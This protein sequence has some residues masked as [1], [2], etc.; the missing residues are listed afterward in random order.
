MNQAPGTATSRDPR[1]VPLAT[2]A[3]TAALADRIAPTLRGGDVL[4]LVGELGTGKTTLVQAMG[5]YWQVDDGQIRSPTFALVNVV[6]LDSFD[7]VHAD[8]YRLNGP[9]D[10][11]SSGLA[12]LLGAPDCVCVVEWPEAAQGLLPPNTLGLTL[13]LDGATGLRSAMPNAEL[14]ARLEQG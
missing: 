6:E 10:V 14:A 13:R 11:I 2:L 7:L 9:E 4:T 3:D 5:R 8:L 1:P 12:E